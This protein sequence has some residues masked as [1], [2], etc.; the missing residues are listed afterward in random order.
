MLISF[1]S[2]KLLFGTA[3]NKFYCFNLNI[4]Y[5]IINNDTL[6]YRYFTKKKLLDI[7]IVFHS[8]FL[9]CVGFLVATF[10]CLSQNFIYSGLLVCVTFVVVTVICLSQKCW[11][12][13]GMR[14]FIFRNMMA[15]MVSWSRLYR[16]LE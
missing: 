10:I 13:F 12:F 8:G 3:V 1:F 4:Y 6:F 16:L 15:L 11:L 14:L 2:G 5:I 9:V 7:I